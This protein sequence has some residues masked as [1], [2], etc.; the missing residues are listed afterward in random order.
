MSREPL[1]DSSQ[2]VNKIAALLRAE[3]F[4]SGPRASLR[5]MEPE[6][7]AE[8]ALQRLLA[9]HVPDEWLGPRGMADWGLIVHALALGSPGNLLGVQSLG[10][11]LARAR[12]SESRLARL[13]QANR[14]QL[15]DALPRACRFLVAR[16]ES[17]HPASIAR[18]VLEVSH[19]SDADAARTQIA[20]DFYRAS[21]PTA[22]TSTQD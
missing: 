16:G 12:F 18:F 3:H 6:S 22:V 11:S 20:R 2:I 13:L 8:P 14:A 9:E 7:T 21:R 4:G 19:S 15:N 10:A 1:P 5:R 17:L